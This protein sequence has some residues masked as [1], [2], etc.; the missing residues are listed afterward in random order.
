MDE[1]K[2]VIS[3]CPPTTPP[4]SASTH[5][6]LLT[7]DALLLGALLLSTLGSLA[8]NAKLV[9]VV[10][11]KLAELAKL[12]VCDTHVQAIIVRAA[13]PIASRFQRLGLSVAH[14][15]VRRGFFLIYLGNSYN[16]FTYKLNIYF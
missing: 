8:P 14:K 10:G 6:P 4:P 1:C 16:Q 11:K 2:Q 13:V 12:S 15:E 7:H 9:N 3:P 5:P